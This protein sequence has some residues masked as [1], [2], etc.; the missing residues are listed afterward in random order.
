MEKPTEIDVEQTLQR[1]DMWKRTAESY[2]YE[3]DLVNEE[4][5]LLDKEKETLTKASSN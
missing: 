1:L 4:I 5:D 2:R 3:V